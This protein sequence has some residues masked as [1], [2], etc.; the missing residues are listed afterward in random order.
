M[1]DLA[2]GTGI[3]AVE[4]AQQNPASTVIGSDLSLIQPLELPNCSFVREDMEEPWVHEPGSLDYIHGRWIYSCLTS[5]ETVFQSA[6]EALVPGG[7]IELQDGDPFIQGEDSSSMKRAMDLF[8][9]GAT[10][11]GRD[12][13]VTRRYKGLL[14]AAGCRFTCI[15]FVGLISSG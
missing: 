6:F 9:A 5:P 3:W 8:I 4:F 14:E 7:W 15:E 1:L 11:I 10:T 13:R 12:F 2:T